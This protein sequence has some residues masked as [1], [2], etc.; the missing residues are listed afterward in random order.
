MDFTLLPAAML[1][2][3]VQKQK[4]PGVFTRGY[5]V[6]LD[7]DG[8]A[9]RLPPPTYRAL[10]HAKPSQEEFTALVEEFWFEAYHVAKYIKRDDLWAVK[11]RDWTTKEPLLKMIE[12]YE[13]SLHD[14]ERDTWHLGV[15]MRDWV[16]PE[17]WQRLHDTFAH[18]DSEDSKHALA[19]TMSLFRDLA[20]KTAANLSYSYPSEVDKRLS[21]YVTS[22]LDS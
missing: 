1:E 5:K 8:L 15:R 18:F 12:W 10:S 11:F 9:S 7:K 20:E 6:L 17:I 13:K 14:W 19:A 2:N 16:E 4:L 22:L 3:D 21:E